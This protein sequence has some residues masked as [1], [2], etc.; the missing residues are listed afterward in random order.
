MPPW[1]SEP[2]FGDFVGQRPLTDSEIDLIQQWI[3][4]GAP[5]GS[6]RDLPRLPRWTDGWQLG[7]PD[8]IVEPLQAYTLPAD[9]T[10]LFRVFV[11]PIPTSVARHV[12]GMEFR[13]DNPRIVHHANILLDRTSTSRERNEEDP[14]LGERGLL[15]ASAVYPDGY[16][17]G[18][19]PGQPDSLL[20]R[21]LSWQLD[22]G[23]DL[24]VQL[25]MKP[26]G[27][28]ERVHFKVAFFFGNDAPQRTPALLRLSRQS[29]DIPAGEKHLTVTDSYVL[30]VDV[31]LLALKPHAHYRAREMRAFAT[32]PDGTTRWLLFIKDWDFQWQHTYRYVS[33]IVLSKGTM[34]TMQYSYDNSADNVRNPEQPPRRVRWGPKSFD[35]MAD[36]WIQV[37]ARDEHDLA[38]LNRDFRSKWAA[39]DAIGYEGRLESEPGNVALHQDAA[40]LY[41]E[42]GRPMDAAAH[43]DATVRLKPGSA[44]SHFNL[45]VG[46]ML[47]GQS[48]RAIAE[49]QEAL[50]INPRLTS[51]H[52]N[53]ANGLA[54]QGR[55]D[56]ALEHYREVVRLDPTHAAALNNIGFIF[57]QRGDLKEG[58]SY[59]REALRLDPRLPDAHYN[60]GLVFQRQGDLPE[61]VRHF[62]DALQLKP[63][64]PRVLAD[65]AWVLGTTSE[66]RLRNPAE[67]VRLAEQAASL[68]GRTD[69]PVLDALAAAYAAT[70]QFGRALSTIQE[71]IR[72]AGALP[73]S[74]D[75]L[76]RQDLYNRHLP[77]RESNAR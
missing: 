12:K 35:E 49:Y 60:L 9:G 68:T 71:A 14:T 22:P 74:E 3:D 41:L 55:F 61:A 48:D 25:H 65:L 16:F 62:R 38:A 37:L 15:A 69:R 17:L 64:W 31:E 73:S 66:S 19:T 46:L 27:K 32:L 67:A 40:M 28:P 18:W 8:L 72:L 10:D 11:L 53:L 20:P 26:S 42:L 21:G 52:Y 44:S 29:I 56:N 5:E 4:G 30:P 47:A 36:L 77:Y 50:R 34:M 7:K 63:D 6:P 39:E 70:G 58:L 24:V 54:A 59:L 2:G 45:G 23:T 57:M 75:L 43:L 51:A 33:P 1:K 76:K 13:P